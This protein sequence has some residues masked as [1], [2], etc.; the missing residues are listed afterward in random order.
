MTCGGCEAA[1]TRAL[2]RVPGVESAAAS[3]ADG[4]VQVTFDP[5]R[6]GKAQLTARIEAL[7][8]A[9]GP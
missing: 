9:V 7:G 1:V 2:L 6:A 4:Q 5:E 8:Y 3:H